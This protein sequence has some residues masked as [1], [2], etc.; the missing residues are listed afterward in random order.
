MLQALMARRLITPPAIW[1]KLPGH[2]DFVRSGMRHGESAGWQ[3]WLARQG[4]VEGLAVSTALPVSFV[5][6]PG[7][8]SFAQ[9]CYVLGVLMPSIDKIGRSHALLVYQLAQLRWLHP[10]LL[11]QL[12][13]PLDWQFWL[14]RAVAR[15][16]HRKVS[17]GI[18][19]LEHS[20]KSLWRLHAPQARQLWSSKF[21]PDAAGERVSMAAQKLL[22]TL[23]GPD[24]PDDPASQ[25]QGVRHF[26]LAAWP[27]QIFRPR[28]EAVFWQQDT[29]G[30]YVNVT[31]RL[32]TLWSGA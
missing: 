16:T 2:A 32:S 18:Q 9:H 17:S 28:R 5:L 10:H 27:Q 30:A 23:V 25:L 13:A 11:A 1:G 21:P 29:T 4:H 20:V 22:E 8:L 19:P 7:T 12:A 26:P 6:A 15:H 3:P 24:A 31:T 14:A